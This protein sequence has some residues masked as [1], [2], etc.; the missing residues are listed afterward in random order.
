MVLYA[1]SLLGCHAKKPKPEAM[2]CVTNI[3]HLSQISLLPTRRLRYYTPASAS[4]ILKCLMQKGIDVMRYGI[5]N[6]RESELIPIHPMKLVRPYTYM[7]CDLNI[8]SFSKNKHISG[9]ALL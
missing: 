5:Q 3:S 8:Y 2:L 1:I 4:D 9:L 6:L 7:A